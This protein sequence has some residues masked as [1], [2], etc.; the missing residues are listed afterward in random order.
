MR[1]PLDRER[2]QMLLHWRHVSMSS[3]KCQRQCRQ[4]FV[5]KVEDSPLANAVFHVV[6]HFTH[7]TFRHFANYSFTYLVL[8]GLLKNRAKKP[9]NFDEQKSET[10]AKAAL[11]LPGFCKWSHKLPCDVLRFGL[12]ASF[13]FKIQRKGR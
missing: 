12:G 5:R 8:F 7:F 2:M 11:S 3:P 13:L 1:P 6:L 9:A 4:G 10:E